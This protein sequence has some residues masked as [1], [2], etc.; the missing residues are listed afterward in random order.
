[1]ANFLIDKV[2]KL[3]LPASFILCNGSL[4]GPIGSAMLACIA[5]K[6]HVPV[7]AVCETYKFADRVNLDQINNNE[8][9]SQ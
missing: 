8:Q 3:Y 9:G 5:H 7:V 1:M 4:V 6:N 2:T